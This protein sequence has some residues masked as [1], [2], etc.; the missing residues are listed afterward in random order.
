MLEQMK[1]P[2]NLM[3]KCIGFEKRL[4]H[5]DSFVLVELAESM[6]VGD[7]VSIDIKLVSTDDWLE[8]DCV[9]WTEK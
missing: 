5:V 8:K 3:M 7:L 2:E 4:M 9:N 1:L 6:E